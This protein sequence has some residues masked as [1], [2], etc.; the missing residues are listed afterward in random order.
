MH[1]VSQ[2]IQ[3]LS[4]FIKESDENLKTLT[5]SEK[6]R[7]L[8]KNGNLHLELRKYTIIANENGYFFCSTCGEEF[9]NRND[10]DGHSLSHITERG[11]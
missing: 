4:Q 8:Y 7:E 5:G 9:K 6:T 10:R 3:Q 1:L 2:S 11:F